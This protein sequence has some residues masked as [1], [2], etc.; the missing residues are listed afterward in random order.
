MACSILRTLL[1]LLLL[2]LLHM[3]SLSPPPSAG[4]RLQEVVVSRIDWV[5]L[6]LAAYLQQ[7]DQ[8]MRNKLTMS[9]HVFL[10]TCAKLI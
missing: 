2:L 6:P 8:D 10:T 7:G 4:I 3:A 1:L 9:N 5:L